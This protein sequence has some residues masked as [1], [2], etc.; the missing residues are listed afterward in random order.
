MSR[1]KKVSKKGNARAWVVRAGIKGSAHEYFAKKQ[2]IVL[3]EPGLGD[4]SRLEPSRE[5]FYKA[6]RAIKPDETRTGTAGIGGKFFRFVHEMQ[7]HDVVIYPVLH[8]GEVHIGR[9]V[10]RYVYRPSDREFPHQ[11]RVEWIGAVAKDSLTVAAQYE[12]GAARTLFEYKRNLE[13]LLRKAKILERG[14][15]SAGANRGR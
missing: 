11:R 5:A 10:G 9:L 7:V 8:T 6:Y 4:L 14:T 12:L 1:Q 15:Q 3:V 13:E 2:A